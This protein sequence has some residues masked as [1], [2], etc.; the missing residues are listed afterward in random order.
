MKNSNTIYLIRGV[1]GSGKSTIAETLRISL[2]DAVAFAA[3]DFWHMNDTME[4]VFDVSRLGDAHQ[5]CKNKV[6]EHMKDFQTENII[7]HNT[8]TTEKE[9]KPYIEMAEEYH[10]NIVSLVVENRHGNKNIHN[11]PDQ[12]IQ[13]Q[14]NK[15]SQNIKLN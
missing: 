12:T 11:V 13:K 6:L 8:F 7:V 5:W 4:Y 1:S 3:D 15:L 10:Y 14:I 9:L 2:S